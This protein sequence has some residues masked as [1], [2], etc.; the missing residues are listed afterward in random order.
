MRRGWRSV[1]KRACITRSAR[2]SRLAFPGCSGLQASGTDRR[3][4]RRADFHDV[5]GPGPRGFRAQGRQQTA[6]TAMAIHAW[7]VSRIRITFS[8]ASAAFRTNVFRL[9]ALIREPPP[10]PPNVCGRA[11]QGGGVSALVASSRSSPMTRAAKCRIFRR[12]I[13]P[14]AERRRHEGCLGHRPLSRAAQDADPDANRIH[15]NSRHQDHKDP[16]DNGVEPLVE[17]QRARLADSRRGHLPGIDQR[18]QLR[19]ARQESDAAG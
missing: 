2:R 1:E 14:P 18:L 11:R 5:I 6:G 19:G 17:D 15:Q 8:K 4:R 7:R 9:Q 12:F 13:P 10:L 16:A 3:F